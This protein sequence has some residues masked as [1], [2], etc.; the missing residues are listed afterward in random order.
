MHRKKKSK[1]KKFNWIR[2]TVIIITILEIFS[3]FN[4]PIVQ[5]FFV[6]FSFG[7][8]C[9]LVNHIIH[10]RWCMLLLLLFLLLEYSVFFLFSF[11]F[12]NILWNRSFIHPSS[13]DTIKYWEN[14]SVFFCFVL[15]TC[16]WKCIENL[17]TMCIIYWYNDNDNVVV[18]VAVAV[19]DMLM[20]V[21]VSITIM[22][23]QKP[24]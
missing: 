8:F 20:M 16:V 17:R 12:T 7:I 3:M 11:I 4:W 18:A 14:S 15:D 9:C 13:F 2:F 22:F 6:F 5:W 24:K 21:S 1:S 10:V 23:T 19:K